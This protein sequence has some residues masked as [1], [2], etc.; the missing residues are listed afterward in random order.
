M[1][2][3]ETTT[4]QEHFFSYIFHEMRTPLTVIH[5]YAQLLQAKLPVTP[6]LQSVR[7]MAATI[8][9]Q[10]DEIVE[11]IEELL[12]A[13]RL[14]LGNLNLD[15]VELD[16]VG[17]LG[18]L[19]EQLPEKIQ[20]TLEW[21]APSSIDSES[22]PEIIVKG[23]APRLTRTFRSILEFA[24]QLGTAISIQF[25]PATPTQVLQIKIAIKGLIKGFSKEEA[26]QLF[27][28]YRPIRESTHPKLYRAGNLDIS[29]YVARGLLENHKGTL[30]YDQE[31]PGF[32]VTLPQPQE[33]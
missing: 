2:T 32:I 19:V 21:P 18:A 7:N 8:V 13:S 30:V 24:A 20:K 3:D 4:L 25:V 31:L 26:A 29:L 14:P 11:M 27:D 5:S 9:N 33:L 10:G 16:L 15:L 1:D 6:E 23:D 22:Y 12:E 17:L 28:L